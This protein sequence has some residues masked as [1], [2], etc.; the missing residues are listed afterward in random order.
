MAYNLNKAFKEAKIKEEASHEFNEADEMR[1]PE[2]VM[3]LLQVDPI[4][5]EF[6]YG[7]LPLV[8]ANQ[9]GD[10]LDRL[11]M[12]RRQCALDLGIVVPVIRLR[13]NIQLKPNEYVI[14]IKGTEV[15]SGEIMFDNYLA[16]NP[17]TAEGELE[18]I[19][20][21]EPAFGL[22]AVWITES[23]RE[24]AEMMGYT[25]VDPPSIIATHLTE[26]I[27]AHAGELLGRQEVQKLLD[28]LKESYPALVDE[29]LPKTLSLGEIH[30][31]LVNLLKENISIRD[32]VTIMETL[33]DYG[34][35]TKDPDILT[36]YVRQ[37]LSRY[38]TKRFINGKKAKFITLSQELEQ[39]IIDSVKQTDY[40]TYISLDPAITQAIAKS[41]MKEIQKFISIGEQP[42]VLTSPSVRMY[43]KRIAEG[44]SPGIIV[45]SYNEIDPSVEVQSI[46]MVNI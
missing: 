34:T 11:V 27:K 42:M 38:I 2:N 16:M 8:D 31:V 15:T 40:G 29:V 5:L 7:I 18:G 35:M 14:K 43:F 20:T 13:D 44:I 30:K 37:S 17:G 33:A 28:N 32:L 26:I 9:G 25:V 12:I 36:E 19:K 41:L 21:V 22:P 45:L 39:T 10:L 24:K 23:Q 1:K 4:E 3:S 6:G 46:G